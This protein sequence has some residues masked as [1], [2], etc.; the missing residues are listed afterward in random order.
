[1]SN[2][3]EAEDA[4]KPDFKTME[5][6]NFMELVWKRPTGQKTGS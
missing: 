3:N 5:I 2:I 4:L 6:H 1:M